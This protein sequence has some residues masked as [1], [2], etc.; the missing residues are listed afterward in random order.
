M[1]QKLVLLTLVLTLALLASTGVAQ[2]KRMNSP[3]LVSCLALKDSNI[4]A[5]TLDS[6]VYLSTNKGLNWRPVN[7]GME[8]LR[9][10]ALT[11]CDSALIAGGYEGI[12]LSTNGGNSWNDDS[13]NLPLTEIY[14]STLLTNGQNIFMGSLMGTFP[15]D[16]F[17][18]T[19]GDTSWVA[20]DSG[21][22]QYSSVAALAINDNDLFAGLYGGFGN[23]G[24]GVYLS[25]NNGS[26]WS[27]INN[28]ISF[29]SSNNDYP[30]VGPFAVIG[31]NL[32]A[33]V[34]G[35][36]IFLSSN[37]GQSWAAADSGLPAYFPFG[38]YDFAV[39]HSSIFAATT[40][41]VF[42]S[43]N[44][45]T[46]WHNVSSELTDTLV[47]WLS[48][49]DTDL[50]A[51]TSDSVFWRRPLSEMINLVNA[52]GDTQVILF[53]DTGT[54]NLTV[55]GDSDQSHPYLITFVNASSDTLTILNAALTDS[56]NRFSISQF[57]PGVPDTVFPGDTFSVIVNFL[58]D[59]TGTVYLDTIVLTIDPNRVI[60]SF[61]VY[62]KGKSFSPG[63]S[64]VL[65]IS[66]ISSSEIQCYP[67]P[68]TQSTKISFTLPESG[69][70]LG[71]AAEV[72]IVNLLGSEVARLFS[73]TLSAG[74]HS[75]EWDASGAAGGTYFCVVRTINGV[76]RVAM[77]VER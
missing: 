44:N 16:V 58:G 11:I 40:N 73:G 26:S 59:T 8:N 43:T 46:S 71:D 2:W 13:K 3:G 28:G 55:A 42:L 33:G 57:L 47:T 72:T 77:V 9:V 23:V 1:K 56:N 67:N 63:P 21:F 65:Q 17:L 19:N 54:M 48:V 34:G 29:D 45:G 18:T 60:T 37:N 39:S 61:Y 27:A 25:T 35:A 12:F 4:F 53:S 7:T 51:E 36:D 76:Q 30:S 10:D 50:F 24:G 31:R 75:F 14:V 70:S 22:P 38:I 41:G 68:L 20:V 6:G 62:L 74:A 32:F 49:G 66:Q 69:A 5:G 15:G 52:P 64:G